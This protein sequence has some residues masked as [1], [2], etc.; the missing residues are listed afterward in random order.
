MKLSAD[1][2]VVFATRFSKKIFVK[3]FVVA[4]LF[5]GIALVLKNI[6]WE[7][8]HYGFWLIVILA[9]LVL[10]PPFSKYFLSEFLITNKRI[11]IQHGFIARRSYEMILTKIESINVNQTLGDR[12]IW[13]SGTL[14]ITGTGGT[15]E[16]FP[17]V[18]GALEF[19]KQLND[20]LHAS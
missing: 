15:N 9:V 8:S 19:Q 3:P 4:I 6:Q 14:A 11:I 5:L 13:G 10:I 1:E 2:K 16:E 18:G 7:Y 20:M 17:N 12:L